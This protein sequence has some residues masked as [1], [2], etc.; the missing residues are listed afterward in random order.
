MYLLAAQTVLDVIAGQPQ[1]AA[2]IRNVAPSDVHISTVA[3]GRAEHAI[4]ELQGPRQLTLLSN[5]AALR[6][7]V[8]TYSGIVAFDYQASSS[9]AALLRF[10]LMRYVDGGQELLDDAGRIDIAVAVARNLQL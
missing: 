10:T 6:G 5:F 3:L 7:N 8:H 1:V 4:R 9:W 2:W